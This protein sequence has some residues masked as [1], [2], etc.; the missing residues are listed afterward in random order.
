[1][2]HSSVD[3]SLSYANVIW[4]NIND[5]YLIQRAIIKFF[6]LRVHSRFL[7]LSYSENYIRSSSRRSWNVLG[8]AAIFPFSFLAAI[9][10]VH[11]SKMNNFSN[12][13]F[14]VGIDV[15]E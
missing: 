10:K 3:L 1:M 13:L 6:F 4:G 12:C 7:F 9:E 8:E 2:H 14:S 11:L 5:S 15:I